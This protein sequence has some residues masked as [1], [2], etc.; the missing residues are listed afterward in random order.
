MI[1]RA[2]SCQQYVYYIVTV[3]LY[4]LDQTSPHAVVTSKI[5]LVS[6]S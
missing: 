6:L 5:R 1:C 2:L 4:L 3:V